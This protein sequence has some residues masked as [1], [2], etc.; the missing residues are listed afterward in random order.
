MHV[1]RV[2]RAGRRDGN[3]CPATLHCSDR[4]LVAMQAHHIRARIHHIMAHIT[5]VVTMAVQTLPR[6]MLAEAQEMAVAAVMEEGDFSIA[7][8][9]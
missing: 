8:S 5:A 7:P 6:A 3:V 2:A 9:I 1:G 4:C